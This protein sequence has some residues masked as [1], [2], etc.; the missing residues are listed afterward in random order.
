MSHAALV[1]RRVL[2]AM[3]ELA[4]TAPLRP[5]SRPERQFRG[6]MAAL[7]HAG[8]SGEAFTAAGRVRLGLP[9]GMLHFQA[10]ERS[11]MSPVRGPLSASAHDLDIGDVTLRYTVAGRGPV[12]L[13]HPGGPGVSPHYLRM[14]PVEQQLVRAPPTAGPT[15]NDPPIAAP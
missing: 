12:C 13:M 7:R 4:G 14:P 11:V 9:P 3:Y 5:G 1:G 2:T 8:L 10:E 15:A 6:G